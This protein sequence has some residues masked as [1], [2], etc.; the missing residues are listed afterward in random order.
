MKKFNSNFAALC[1][2]ALLSTVLTLSSCS[3]S[4]EVTNLE[5]LEKNRR[6]P[7]NVHISEFS[8]SME[9]L[10][11]TRTTVAPGSYADVKAITLAFY[12]TDG[13]EMYK[14]TQLKNDESVTFGNFTC[15]LPVGT[16]TMVV[17]GRDDN[18]GDVFTLTSPTEAG[19][20]SDRVWETFCKTQSV[21]VTSTE[22]L[23]LNVTLSR[24]VTRLGI[25]STDPRPE[26]AIKL[27]TTYS[28]GGKIFNPTTS[29]ALSN[30]GFV[31]INNLT[32]PVGQTIGISNFAFLYSDEQT[33]DITL[34]VLDADD[35]VII[36]K[37]IPNVPFKCNRMTAL[38]GPVFTP[39][40]TTASFTLE[41]E[42][43]D[44]YYFDF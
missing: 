5:E 15:N 23:N 35:E 22:A 39:A 3:G 32:K 40:A 6:V 25:I 19:Y 14:D 2:F 33:M 31:Q 20:S 11:S 26:G 8:F 7:V 41:K 27:R 10:P 30:N 18:E 4:E 12:A 42:W 24:I 36:S 37:V 29:L 44:D 16:Y 21:T 17:I 1:G 9:D 28:K 43:I 38:R 13:T 34:E